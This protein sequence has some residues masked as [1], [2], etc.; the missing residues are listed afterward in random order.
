M[1]NILI[2]P[3]VLISA[4]SH[5]YATSIDP[6]TLCTSESEKHLSKLQKQ[7]ET[8]FTEFQYD[9]ESAK[10]SDA[11]FTDL[12]ATGSRRWRKRHQQTP[13][14]PEY[15][16]MLVMKAYGKEKTGWRNLVL[17]CGVNKGKIETFT[18]EILNVAD[19]GPVTATASAA[20]PPA[21]ASAVPAVTA[22]V[23]TPAAATTAST[24]VSASA[25]PA[26]SANATAPSPPANVTRD[27]AAQPAP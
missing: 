11:E 21:A 24:T 5:A 3:M 12:G 14:K 25:E 1:K 20:T 23:A 10:S 4:V 17:K 8:R 7:G 9:T 19:K 13:A 6:R 27:A 22:T 15:G 2:L 16:Q 26:N 18:Y